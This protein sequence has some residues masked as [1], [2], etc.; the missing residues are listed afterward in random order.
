MAQRS[1]PSRLCL[2]STLAIVLGCGGTSGSK[3]GD[4]AAGAAGSN[5]GDAA[6][7]APGSNGLLSCDIRPECGG[8]SAERV[9]I[10][11][12]GYGQIAGDSAGTLN[13]CNTAKGILGSTCDLTGAV[14]GCQGMGAGAGDY[15]TYTY[16]YYSGSVADVTAKCPSPMTVVMPPAGSATDGGAGQAAACP[17]AGT[18]SMGDGGALLRNRGP[19]SG[20]TAIA[21][22]AGGS[23]AVVAGGR[24]ACWGGS[25][26]ILGNLG[27]TGAMDAVAQP[28]LIP[29][30]YG[31]TQVAMGSTD[32]F[33][34]ALLQDGTVAC[35]GENN[36]DELGSGATSTAGQGYPLPISGLTGVT[37]ISAGDRFVCALAG[38]EVWCWG[39]NAF[40]ELGYAGN[41]ATNSMP[42]Q[43][44]GL[45]NVTAISAGSQHACAIS[46][47]DVLCWGSNASAESGAASATQRIATPTQVANLSGAVSVTAG[48]A[49]SFAVLSDGSVWCWGACTINTITGNPV[50]AQMT[51]FSHALS[52][53]VS[54]SRSC[55]LQT[56]GTA[57]CPNDATA[58][59]GLTGVKVIAVG[60]G[61]TCVLVGDGAQCWG[62]NNSGQL[63]NGTVAMKLP[64]GTTMNTDTPSPVIDLG[65]CCG[66]G[67]GTFS[68]GLPETTSVAALTAGQFQMLCTGARGDTVGLDGYCKV[69]GILAASAQSTAASDAMLATACQ[70]EY[71][72]CATIT[73][74]LSPSSCSAVT[75]SA[76]CNNVHVD[77]VEACLNETTAIGDA[78]GPLMPS[79]TALTRSALN[80]V[81]PSI[82]ITAPSCQAPGLVSCQQIFVSP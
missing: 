78:Y 33:A 50:P 25:G 74:Q 35:W 59:A 43:I 62:Q 39:L 70:T 8:S 15:I 9:C 63:G 66:G 72:S 30:I 61:I 29:G 2:V 67:A 1:N 75:T 56:G 20:V 44:P 7:G 58:V 41:P 65:P 10:A 27:S 79:C 77:E 80:A 60:A 3:A 55:A 57:Q 31:A 73:P 52:L 76:A 49:E 48:Q 82:T 6:A 37:A 45:S 38:G 28:I 11:S 26:V 53:A 34:C 71:T 12:T 17:D 18:G 54:G 21:I 19:L 14:A 13:N 4:G 5:A 68:S 16:W 32:S 40:D 42:A 69:L 51:A 47:G 36:N 23:C 22:G 81:D 64:N 24:V 46:A